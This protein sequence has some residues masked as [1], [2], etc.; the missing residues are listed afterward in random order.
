[1]GSRWL[2]SLLALACLGLAIAVGFWPTLAAIA[3]WPAMLVLIF[4][5][6]L[7]VGWTVGG[8]PQTVFVGKNKTWSLSVT[9]GVLWTT[10]VVSALITAFVFRLRGNVGNPLEVLTDQNLLLLMGLPITTVAAASAITIGKARSTKEL[11]KLVDH[12]LAFARK[13]HDEL[14]GTFEREVR[15]GQVQLVAPVRGRT[16]QGDAT[17]SVPADA[18]PARQE[19]PDVA[20][21][22]RPRLDQQAAQATDQARALRQGIAATTPVVPATGGSTVTGYVDWLAHYVAETRKG[23]LMTNRNINEA[24]FGDMLSGDEWGDE[25]G[26]DFGKVQFFLISLMAMVAYCGALGMMFA[27]LSVDH[28]TDTRCFENLPG[29]EGALP[30]VLFMSL[31]GYLGLKGIPSTPTA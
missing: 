19:W 25:G 30:S 14:Q 23:T 31:A 18:I 22:L 11:P 20:A 3:V 16:P 10:I 21:G 9:Q 12:Q 4:L 13:Y 8:A 28:C 1:M 17:R 29:L 15:D 5:F 26:T 6:V 27:G 24:R 2:P 7:F